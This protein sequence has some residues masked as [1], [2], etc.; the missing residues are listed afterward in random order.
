MKKILITLS[1][2][3]LTTA[4]YAQSAFDKFENT[5]DVKVVIMNKN[6]FKMLSSFKGAVADDPEAQQ[7]MELIQTLDN[8]RVF[9]TSNKKV[10]LDMENTFNIY[11]KN[12]KLD[13]LMRVKENNSNIKFYVKP[14]KTENMV[15]ELLMFVNTRNEQSP[16]STETIILSIT[17]LIDLNKI[18]ALTEKMNIPGGDQIGKKKN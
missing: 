13:E 4:T 14:G 11:L 9:S 7:Y 18:S 1:L 6:L 10:A 17:G 2:V 16:D 5:E 8:L 15:N 3:I 12:N